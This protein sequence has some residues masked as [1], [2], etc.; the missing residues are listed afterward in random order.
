[1]QGRSSVHSGTP[2]TSRYTVSPCMIITAIMRVYD[3][4]SPVHSERWSS[5][6]FRAQFVRHISTPK[7]CREGGGGGLYDFLA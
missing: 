7:H 3:R 5:V 6:Y 2:T 4:S 1:M